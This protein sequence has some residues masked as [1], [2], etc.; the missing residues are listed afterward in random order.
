MSNQN[1][2]R[3]HEL[4]DQ[5]QALWD[6]LD[7]L[8]QEVP[9][10]DIEEPAPAARKPL[11]AESAPEPAEEASARAPVTRLRQPV[12]EPPAV[13]EPRIEVPEPAVDEEIDAPA[14]EIPAETEPEPESRIGAPE[15]VEGAV[16]EEARVPE[17]AEPD[18]QALIFHVGG[19][20]LAVPLVKLHSVVPWED[21]VTPMPNQPGW[22]HGLFHYRG[23]NVRVVDTAT[24]VLPADKRAEDGADQPEQILVVGD[25]RWAMSCS[26]VGDVVRLK[27]AEVKWR[28]ANGQRPW[29]A[30]TVREKL[31]AVMDTEAFADMLDSA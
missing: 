5:N 16:P 7:A 23:H 19:L 14:D 11:F 27:P 15:T 13:P 8:L 6:Y 28:T 18:F 24:L 22:C 30:G 26:R 17:W 4:S 2:A 3:T 29:L 9:E 1:L 12:A 25:G 31:C 10:G 21:Q 20:K